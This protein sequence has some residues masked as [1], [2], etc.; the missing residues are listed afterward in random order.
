MGEGRLESGIFVK[1]NKRGGVKINWYGVGI[2]K[3]PL[4]L[5]MNEKKD[6]C[7][8]YTLN[9]KLSKQTRNEAS[10]NKVIIKNQKSIRHTNKLSKSQ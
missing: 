4:I 2:S 6:K 7:L 10:K 8:I 3:Y 5:V 9:L 1:L